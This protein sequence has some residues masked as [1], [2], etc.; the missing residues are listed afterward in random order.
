MLKTS[1]KIKKFWI[2][3]IAADGGVGTDW[4]ELQI[5]TREATMSFSGSDA[6]TTAYKNVLGSALESAKSKGDKTLN[7]QFADL[8]PSEIA[9]LTGGT[10]TESTDAITYEAPENENQAIEK[11]LRFLTDKNV[12][13]TIPRASLDAYPTVND[14][15]LHFYQVNTMVLTPQKTGVTSYAYAVLLKP[16]QND[17]VSFTFGTIDSAPAT[18]NSTLHTVA[19]TI[20]EATKTALT[21]TIG[22]SLG[23]S[24]IPESGDVADYTNPV[25]YVVESADGTKQNWVVTVTTTP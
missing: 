11:S 21:P 1:I 12:L 14:D 16:E 18:I 6:D 23:A 20:T 25:T 19:I 7:F 22:V 10:V 17:I 9:M 5:G 3:N 2:A 24:V 13:F 4:H 8:T 15:D